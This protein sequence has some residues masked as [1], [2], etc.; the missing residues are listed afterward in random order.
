MIIA[1]FQDRMKSIRMEK[2]SSLK[3]IAEKIAAKFVG[4][5]SFFWIRIFH[6]KQDLKYQ[7]VRKGVWQSQVLQHTKSSEEPV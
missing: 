4:K 1:C 2:I 5:G 6:E 3:L 7:F